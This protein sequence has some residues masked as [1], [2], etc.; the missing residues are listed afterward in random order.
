MD[1]V[2]EPRPGVSSKPPSAFRSRCRYA[3]AR[4]TGAPR[5][6][7]LSAGP[8]PRRRCRSSRAGRPRTTPSRRERA[9]RRRTNRTAARG[10]GSPAWRRARIAPDRRVDRRADRAARALEVANPREQP[11]GPAAE[12][13]LRQ[14]DELDVGRLGQLALV[15]DEVVERPARARSR[16]LQPERG[17]GSEL[18]AGASR[19]ARRSRRPEPGAPGGSA[20]GVAATA[21]AATAAASLTPIRPPPA[22]AARSARAAAAAPGPTASASTKFPLAWR[23]RTRCPRA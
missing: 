19:S 21:V 8:A 20:T 5:D 16:G 13:A 12:G 11:V 14:R 6:A 18:R 15:G 10:A 1:C 7:A 23:R 9:W 2:S 4:R 17:P 3:S 22:G